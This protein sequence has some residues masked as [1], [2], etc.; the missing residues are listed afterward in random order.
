VTGEEFEAAYAALSGVTVDQL[1]RW[2]R[3][4]ERCWCGRPGCDGWVMGHQQED[5]IVEDQIRSRALAVPGGIPEPN[6]GR[7]GACGKCGAWRLDGRPPYLHKPGC[8][9]EDDLQLD[10]YFD[11]MA[12]GD[13]GGPTLYADEAAAS[14]AR[15]L[16]VTEAAVTPPAEA[17]PE[18]LG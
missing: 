1:H 5:A 18:A 2:G 3:Y 9:H 15:E 17:R 10:R 16:G 12:R 6:P 14:R 7:V 11:E 13:F 8:P 4:A